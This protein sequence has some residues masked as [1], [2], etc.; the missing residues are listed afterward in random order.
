[1]LLEK[2]PPLYAIT[3]SGLSHLSHSNQVRILV[4]SGVKLIQMREKKVGR[5]FFEEIVKSVS[6]SR[7]R[8]ALIIVNDRVDMALAAG[9]DGV[10][11]GE[12][13]LPPLEARRILGPAK[14]IGV[15]THSITEA[16]QASRMDVNYLAIGPIF[17]TKTKDLKYSPLGR[18]AIAEIK[19]TVDKPLVAIGGITLEKVR[20]IFEA[21]AD[22]VAIISDLLCRGEPGERARLFLAAIE[23]LKS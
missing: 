18:E 20:E 17:K 10:H 15:S 2:I 19:R 7:E 23:S 21:G 16:I 9:A 12:E 13:D 8:G 6:Y 1:M 5:D 11:L 4:D 14:I 22:S 3:D